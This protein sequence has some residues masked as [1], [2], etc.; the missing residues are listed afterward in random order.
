MN[1]MIAVMLA[2]AT[3]T[4]EAE[5]LGREL[6]EAG[7]LAALLPVI[8]AKETDEVIAAHPGLSD[9]E[10]TALRVTAGRVYE[11][12][13]DLPVMRVDRYRGGQPLRLDPLQGAVAVQF[14]P[15]AVRPLQVSLASSARSANVASQCSPM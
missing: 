11:Q 4:A 9:S 15:G 2:S 6:A 5:R 13:R 10:K 12:G 1:L 8:Q 3:P 14:L 7:T